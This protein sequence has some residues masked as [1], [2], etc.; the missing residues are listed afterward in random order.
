MTKHEIVKAWLEPVITEMALDRLNFNFSPESP[1]TVA[2][3][4]DYSDRIVRRFINDDVEMA[5][6]FTVLITKTYSSEADDLNLEA[7][8]F[9]Q[10]LIDWMDEQNRTQAFPDLG[11]D[12]EVES[13]EPLQNMPNLAGV[14]AEEGL[15]RY[16]VQGRILYRQYANDTPVPERG[17]DGGSFNPWT[18][19]GHYDGGDF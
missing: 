5:Y 10:G 7:M 12:T 11:E 19:I 16:Q 6:G 9:A 2:I 1:D 4:T 3:I 17:M 15:A 13:I 14:N 18:S 8:N